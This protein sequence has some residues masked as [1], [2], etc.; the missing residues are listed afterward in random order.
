M[1]KF[2]EKS[3]Y[4]YNTPKMPGPLGVLTISIDEKDGIICV[5]KM[6]PDAVAAK[7]AAVA[8]PTK[9]SK[10]KK[11]DCRTSSKESGKRAPPSARHPLTTC[12]S[13]PTARDPR[14]L[15]PR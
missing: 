9:A 5:D 10:G 1:A 4:A 13:V 8:G 6:Y 15:H 11:R 7:A 2:M 3:Q 12:R 14:L